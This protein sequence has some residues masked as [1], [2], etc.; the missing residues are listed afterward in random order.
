VPLGN[1]V[2]EKL[3]IYFPKLNKIHRI[4]TRKN[5]QIYQ[6]N[7]QVKICPKKSLLGAEGEPACGI[8]LFPIL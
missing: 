6:K 7:S 4:Y 3:A 2:F 5:T 1:R 8:S